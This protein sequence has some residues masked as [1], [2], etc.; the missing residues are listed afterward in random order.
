[1]QKPIDLLVN[2]CSF[3]RGP[4]AWPYHLT[5][6]N[7]TNIA[8]AG[9]G[10]TYIHDSTISEL[11]KRHYDFVAVM[12]SG[13]ARIDFK[14]S[15]I[16]QFKESVYTS[17]YQSANNDWPSKKIFPIN[18]QDYTEKD[19]VFGCG[20]IN[21]EAAMVKSKLFDQI[22]YYQALKQLTYGLLIKMVSLQNTLKQLKIPYLFAYY[23]DYEKELEQWPELYAI[24]DK[25]NIYNTQ[26]IYNIT[27]SNNW[28]DAD[29]IHPGLEAHQMWARLIQPMIK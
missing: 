12:W 13:I 4:T 1:M 8:C 25:T 2:G 28:Y 24:L 22:Y 9:A 16:N 10:N 5:G 29:G 26:N 19:W 21:Q 7:L 20:F 18:D 27:K 14:V 6:V 23:N 15:N 3:S 17:Q 11:S